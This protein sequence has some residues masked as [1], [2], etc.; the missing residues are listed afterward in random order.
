MK[1]SASGHVRRENSG[2]MAAQ[3]GFHMIVT[4][5]A[6]WLMKASPSLQYYPRFINCSSKLDVAAEEINLWPR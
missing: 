4:D 3:N 6:A 5:C 1:K 2:T